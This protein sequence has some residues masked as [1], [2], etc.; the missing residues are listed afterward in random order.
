MMPNKD[1]P[2]EGIWRVA[3]CLSV[4]HLINNNT[5]ADWRLPAMCIIAYIHLII[6][7]F[8]TLVHTRVT[9]AAFRS[10]T[11]VFWDWERFTI[12]DSARSDSISQR[13]KLLEARIHTWMRK[14]QRFSTRRIPSMMG[15]NGRCEKSR[16]DA[17]YTYGGSN[18]EIVARINKTVI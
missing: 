8:L 17:S 16:Q 4:R 14:R 6:G 3:W 18:R 1:E 2:H 7:R 11:N 9:S 10:I 5:Q 13:N 15:Y 12:G